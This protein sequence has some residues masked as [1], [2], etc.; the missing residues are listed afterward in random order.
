MNRFA[1]SLGKTDPK[2]SN[3][4]IV[5]LRVANSFNPNIAIDKGFEMVYV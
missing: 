3:R 4:L 2:A 1:E 5:N